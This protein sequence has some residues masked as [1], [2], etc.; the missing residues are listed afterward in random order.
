MVKKNFFMNV[1]ELKGKWVQLKMETYKRGTNKRFLVEG[2]SNPPGITQ[3]FQNDF[4][5][6]LNF[7]EL[8]I[9]EK[10][11]FDSEIPRWW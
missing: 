3:M 10:N 11:S 8:R 5:R 1:Q 9:A 7:C 4:L 2:F 6:W